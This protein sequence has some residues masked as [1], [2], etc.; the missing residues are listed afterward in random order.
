LP[1]LLSRAWFRK[2][3]GDCVD[4]LAAEVEMLLRVNAH[5]NVVRFLAACFETGNVFL[6]TELMA[7]SLERACVHG[8]WLHCSWADTLRMLSEAAA[9]VYHLSLESV[10]HR[11]AEQPLAGSAETRCLTLTPPLRSSVCFASSSAACLGLLLPG[12]L[13]TGTLRHATSWWTPPACVRWRTLD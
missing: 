7:T 11:C 5:P 1:M 8:H 9:G 6:L 3:Y 10:I 2:R 4:Q 12:W 13:C